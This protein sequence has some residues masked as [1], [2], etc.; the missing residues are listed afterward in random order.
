MF[1]KT[2]FLIAKPDEVKVLDCIPLQDIE[3][4]VM[5]ADLIEIEHFTPDLRQAL[6]H[7]TPRGNILGVEIEPRAPDGRFSGHNGLLYWFGFGESLSG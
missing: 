6:L 7:F 5:D 2:S 4:V 1:T 3:E